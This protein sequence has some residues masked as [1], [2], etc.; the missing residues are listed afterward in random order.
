MDMLYHR[1]I[2]RLFERRREGGFLCA[3]SAMPNH[4][5][6]CCIPLSWYFFASRYSFG[7]WWHCGFLLSIRNHSQKVKT[8]G[9]ASQLS[10]LVV[11][12]EMSFEAQFLE[13]FVSGLKSFS[14]CLFIPVS[15]YYFYRAR[16]TMMLVV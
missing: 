11:A 9:F 14:V 6:V 4:I 3:L 1:W 10:L 12:L 5:S 15:C 7:K 16:D 2:W 8:V 13:D